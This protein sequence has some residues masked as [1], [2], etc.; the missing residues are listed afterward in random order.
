MPLDVRQASF[1]RRTSD[2]FV[3]VSDELFDEILKLL[4]VL[5][6]VRSKAKAD[7]YVAAFAKNKS[8][9]E[10][11]VRAAIA[12]ATVVATSSLSEPEKVEGMFNEVF[13]PEK[14]EALFRSRLARVIE[15]ANAVAGSIRSAVQRT[16]S[17]RGLLPYFEEIN[18]TVELRAVLDDFSGQLGHLGRPESRISGLEPIASIRVQLDSGFPDEI[19]FQAGS[20]D[21]AKMIEA[22]QETLSRLE[23]LTDI[24]ASKTV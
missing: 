21:I 14:G 1:L 2:A 13:D 8:A 12:W 3:G 20:A 11:E 19:V 23:E 17:A 16:A 9:N 15:A 18:A 7:E 24:V 10:E 6:G 5:M 4:P 22:L